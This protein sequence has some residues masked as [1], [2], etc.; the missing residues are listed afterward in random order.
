MK[1]K[2]ENEVKR[3]KRDYEGQNQVFLEPKAFNKQL[4][5]P[6]EECHAMPRS[7]AAHLPAHPFR[8]HRDRRVSMPDAQLWPRERKGGCLSC[9]VRKFDSKSLSEV[10]LENCLAIYGVVFVS[11]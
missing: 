3:N 7:A 9:W 11:R 8:L 10:Y 4:L 2:P 1:K 6:A 5:A